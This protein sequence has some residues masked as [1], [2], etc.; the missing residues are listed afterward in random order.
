MISDVL[1][2]LVDNDNR[3]SKL[4]ET[5]ENNSIDFTVESKAM[6][7]NI[8]VKLGPS[9]SKKNIIVLGAHYD[10]FLGSKGINDNTCAIVLLLNFIKLAKNSKLDYPIEVVFF[11]KEESG[12]VGSRNYAE[13]HYKKIDY[14]LIFDIIGFGD[15]L[16]SSAKDMKIIPLLSKMNIVNTTTVL[17]SDN[18]MFEGYDIPVALITAMHTKDLIS[19]PL[20]IGSYYISRHA[21]FYRSFHN[22]DK[23]NDISIINFN[24]IKQLLHALYSTFLAN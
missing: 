6:A 10:L 16:V 20:S 1:E 12:M 8:I 11:D 21:E 9:N 17:P 4:K 19:D 13:K 7:N 22:R 2:L 23:D 18:L 24:L 14:A 15:I 3:F 5:L